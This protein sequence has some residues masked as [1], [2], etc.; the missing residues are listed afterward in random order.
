MTLMDSFPGFFKATRPYIAPILASMINPSLETS[1]IPDSWCC[2]T[3]NLI[4]KSFLTGDQYCSYLS[5]LESVY[6][7]VLEVSLEGKM[8]KS[9]QI[10]HSM[11]PLFTQ[12]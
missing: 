4:S 8:V 11:D 3:F 6:F 1:H 10:G 7:K 2:A 5:S 12:F 9:D